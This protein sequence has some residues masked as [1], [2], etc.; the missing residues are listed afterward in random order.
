MYTY[1]TV[2]EVQAKYANNVGL[3]N[4][5]VVAV[6]SNRIGDNMYLDFGTKE[7]KAR[8]L[9][10]MGVAEPL[11]SD[12]VK[13]ATDGFAKGNTFK[14][15]ISNKC[16]RKVNDAI[17]YKRKNLRNNLRGYNLDIIEKILLKYN[18]SLL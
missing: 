17:K 6:Y 13:T 10:I 4:D 5:C 1:L 14:M 12:I 9:K 16:A 3:M 7:H 8:Y 15:E 11:V 18:L 2:E